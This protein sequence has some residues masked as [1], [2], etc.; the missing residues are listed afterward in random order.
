MGAAPSSS[1]GGG[2]AGVLGYDAVP[3]PSHPVLKHQVV[4]ATRS[5]EPEPEPE[6]EPH[7]RPLTLR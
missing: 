2:G 6:Q 3:D 1:G 4:A 5:G 7:A